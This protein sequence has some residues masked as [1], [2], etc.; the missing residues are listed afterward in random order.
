MPSFPRTFGRV[1]RSAR[2]LAL[3]AVIFVGGLVPALA[4]GRIGTPPGKTSTSTTTSP[5]TTAGSTTSPGV[6]IDA[7]CNQGPVY[8][9]GLSI[10]GSASVGSTLSVT[11]GSWTNPFGCTGAISKTDSWL[12]DGSAFGPTG[13]SYVVQP[14]D[15][16]HSLSVSEQACNTDGFC[17]N[18]P[19]NSISIPAPPSNRPPLAPFALV[20]PGDGTTNDGQ[21]SLPF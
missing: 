17:S 1:Q 13:S 16:G 15:Q 14:A 2:W 18:Q 4:L 3:A 20:Q 10:G 12:R 5:T 11:Q 9:G 6:T 19:S 8:G 7:L 21:G